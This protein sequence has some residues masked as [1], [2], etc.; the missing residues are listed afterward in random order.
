MK[1]ILASQNKHKLEEIEEILKDLD[2]EI[3]SMGEA[4]LGDLEIIEDG[5]TFEDNSLKKAVTVMKKTNTAAIADDSG[6][7]VDYLDGRPGVYSAR[8]S[9]EDATDKENND[10]LLRLLKEV[11]LEERLA[12]FVSVI[13]VVFPEGKKLCIRGECN[14]VIGFEPKG[15]GGFGYDPLFMVPEYN[16]TFAELGNGVK[17]KISHRARALDKLKVEL[18]NVLGDK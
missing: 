16:K 7:E 1:F 3:I 4:G 11:P 12:K 9:G 17:N 5:K 18:K 10:K 8:F 6:L 15:E 14:G 13:T 2:I